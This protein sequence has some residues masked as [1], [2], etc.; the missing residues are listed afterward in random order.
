MI[1]TTTLENMKKWL[2]PLIPTG[3]PKWLEVGAPIEKK[4]LNIAARFWLCFLSSTIMPS[5]NKS[6]LLHTKEAC[7]GCIIDKT[8]IN[9]GMIMAQKMVMRAKQCQTSLPFPVLITKL[10]RRAQIPRDVKKDMEVIPTSS[11]DIQ[12][13]KAEYLKDEAE[14]KKAAPMESS[15]V[16]TIY[17]LPAEAPLPTPRPRP[18]GTSSVVPFDTPGSSTAPL[19]PRSAATISRPP[20]TQ[21][22]LLQMGQLA[23]FAN[24]RAVRLEAS[25][26]GMIQTTHVYVV[27]PLSA[28]IY[29]LEARI[30]VCKRGQGAH[31]RELPD[32]PVDPDM[33]PATTGDDVRVA[34]AVDPDFEPETD[35]EMIGVSE[36]VS[37]KGLTEIVEA[38]IDAAV[39]TSLA[40]TPLVDPSGAGDTVDVTPGIDAQ[41]QSVAPGTDALIYGS[42]M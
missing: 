21:A 4:D 12:R 11:T 32:V 17:T 5:Q 39:Q 15:P 35:E 23:H 28:T 41:N 33:P 6:I 14:K 29:A 9:M 19:P 34:E 26:P 13:I 18:S 27:T 1:R 8:R 7:L 31:R 37:Y 20:L 3:T 30:S 42:T 40:D 22:A 36:E 16:V 24:R 38:M 10:C 2:A 25:I